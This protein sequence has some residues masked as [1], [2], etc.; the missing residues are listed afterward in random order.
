MRVLHTSDTH[1]N[2]KK[3][4]KALEAGGFDVW[5]D[6]G[7]FFP[8]KTRG[9]A[10]IEVKFQTKW[11]GY[12]NLGKR[13]VAALDGRPLVSVGGNHDYANLAQIVR[14]AG[15]TAYDMGDGAAVINGKTFAG[16]REIPWIM[17]EWNG[18]TVNGDFGPIVEK[19]LGA[20]PDVLV[21]HAPPAGILDDKTHGGGISPLTTALTWQPHNVIAHFFGHIHETQGSV[22]EMGIRFIN[23]AEKALTHT[24]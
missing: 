1:G 14:D 8:N 7:D 9:N 16:F 11:V 23:G 19:A 21:T 17:G 4:L 6:T 3:V 15:G 10:Q 12:K 13:I 18:E 24:L 5:I 2:Y 20:N 22:T